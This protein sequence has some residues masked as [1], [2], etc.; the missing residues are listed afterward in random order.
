MIEGARPA[1]EIDAGP[2]L[3][4]RHRLSDGPELVVAATV[5][6]EH[7]R[8]WFEWAQQLPSEATMAAFLAHSVSD[9]DGGKD[10]GY[11][12]VRRDAT[13]GTERLV[14]G[15]GIHDRIAPGGLEI[16]YWVHVE[17][18]GQG[19][20]SATA[21]ALRDQILSIGMDRAEIHCDE[22][23]IASA[24]VARRAGFELIETRHRPARTPS[25]SD[26]EM[27][28]CFS[29]PVRQRDR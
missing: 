26:R 21:V 3:L 20:A 24:G 6:H 17:H 23:N 19:W 16:G 2:V 13:T 15:C 7:L 12:I 11:V 1:E 5:S 4:R 22:R 27:I 29:A 18:I 14:G 25:E 9:F 8:P 10:F 28:W